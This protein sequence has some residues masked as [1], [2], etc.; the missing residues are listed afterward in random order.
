MEAGAGAEA[1][2]VAA[3]AGAH[4][5]RHI[6]GRDGVLAVAHH[7]ADPHWRGFSSVVVLQTGDGTTVVDM[8]DLQSDVIVAGATVRAGAAHVFAV[9]L[10]RVSSGEAAMRLA[11]ARTRAEMLKVF[12]LSV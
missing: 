5:V 2:V 1:A 11:E 8:N 7:D 3:G 4:V 9:H 12:I 10:A 6:A